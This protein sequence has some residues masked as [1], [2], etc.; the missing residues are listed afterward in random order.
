MVAACLLTGCSQAMPLA[1]NRAD[2]ADTSPQAGVNLPKGAEILPGRYVE[3]MLQQCSRDVP[4]Q[5]EGSWD[6]TAAQIV[7]L[8]ARI[9]QELRAEVSRFDWPHVTAEERADYMTSY[10]SWPSGF[11]RQY[12]GMVRQGRQYILGNFASVRDMGE[13]SPDPRSPYPV[14]Q[15]CDGGPDYFGVEYD[16]GT[17]RITHWGFNGG[18]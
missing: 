3:Q 2:P 10:P 13:A 9:G 14:F 8:E 12:V 17:D 18:P 16:V 15:V 11:R 1:D 5:G 4:R 7:R 6:P